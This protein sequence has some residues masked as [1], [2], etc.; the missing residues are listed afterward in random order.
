MADSSRNLWRNVKYGTFIEVQTGCACETPLRDF[1][2]LEKDKIQS[3]TADYSD[4]SNRLFL[5]FSV[6]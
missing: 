3:R 4:L 1:E 5:P 2:E 6:L